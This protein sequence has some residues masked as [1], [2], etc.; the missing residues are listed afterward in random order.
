MFNV[1]IL[2]VFC[3]KTE[4][5]A[6]AETNRQTARQPIRALEFGSASSAMAAKR[7]RNSNISRIVAVYK[8][9][10]NSAN[11]APIILIFFLTERYEYA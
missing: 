4:I 6:F 9:C 5:L 2:T 11:T 10:R 8:I 1:F 3:K 7:P